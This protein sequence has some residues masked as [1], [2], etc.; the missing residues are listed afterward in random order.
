MNIN[1][2]LKWLHGAMVE[3]R[4]ARRARAKGMKNAFDFIFISVKQSN[5]FGLSMIQIDNVYNIKSSGWT[6]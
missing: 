3:D 1:L 2:L 6:S 4:L 5:V